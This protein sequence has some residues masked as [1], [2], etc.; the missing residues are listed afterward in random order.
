MGCQRFKFHVKGG[1]EPTSLKAPPVMKIARHG[2]PL[3][4]TNAIII[5]ARR[6]AFPRCVNMAGLLQ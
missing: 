1:V 6:Y 4:R 3:I 5:A 2:A